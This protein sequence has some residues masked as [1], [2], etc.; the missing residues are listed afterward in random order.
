MA[1]DREFLHHLHKLMVE[2]SE[3]LAE[4]EA[5]YKAQ[6]IWT[7]QKTNNAAAMPLAYKDAAITVPS[8]PSAHSAA[9]APSAQPFL[10]CSC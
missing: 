9:P 6:L 1:L 3:K 8:L 2:V 5:E 10:H 4:P 7:A